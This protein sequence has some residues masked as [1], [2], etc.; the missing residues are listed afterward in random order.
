MPDD[1]SAVELRASYVAERSG[2]GGKPAQAAQPGSVMWADLQGGVSA[3]DRERPLV[4]GVNG[5]L[6]ARP[7]RRSWA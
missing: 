5:P 1:S 6:M 2:L 4:T 7:S 3:S